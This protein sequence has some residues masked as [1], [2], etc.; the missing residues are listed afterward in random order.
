MQKYQNAIQDVNGNA[1]AGA[2][3]A[4]YLYGTTTPAT[5][6][7]DNGVTPIVGN[8]V[9]TSSV[10]EFFFYAANGRYSLTVTAVH[11]TS[12][13]YND[14]TLFDS[15]DY[16]APIGAGLPLQTGNSGKV[17]YTNGTN[18][19]WGAA[20][21]AAGLAV[22][23]P[24]T[25]YAVG[26]NV[27]APEGRP[28][29]CNTAH[30][31]AAIYNCLNWTYPSDDNSTEVDFTLLPNGN[32]GTTVPTKGKV[33]Y[34][35]LPEVSWGNYGV[36]SGRFTESSPGSGPTVTYYQAQLPNSV[37]K[38]QHLWCEF[39][40]AAS[41]S[42]GSGV[43]MLVGNYLFA[44][45][46]SQAPIHWG[47]IANVAGTPSVSWQS[48]PY[49]IP[50]SANG[51]Q[52]DGATGGLGMSPY[53]KTFRLD[54]TMD[55][56][57]GHTCG[58]INGQLALE[59]T[60]SNLIGYMTSYGGFEIQ[61]A[62]YKIKRFGLSAVLPDFATD[63]SRRN[64]WKG[65]NDALPGLAAISIT[66][67]WK[68]VST[69]VVSYDAMGV[70]VVDWTPFITNTSAGVVVRAVLATNSET[71]ASLNGAYYHNK[72][73]IGSFN[74]RVPFQAMRRGTP[75]T[76]EQVTLYIATESG[77]ATLQDQTYGDKIGGPSWRPGTGVN[78]T[79]LWVTTVAPAVILNPVP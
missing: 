11:F 52:F 60:D 28:I 35:G 48:G 8:S 10:G 69:F 16:T 39:E 34:F 9:T 37:D 57:T 62:S 3:V 68:S 7:S 33:V 67:T 29:V 78:L 19:N 36:V 63:G 44:A 14:I 46:P 73:C 26:A 55:I 71:Q 24:F 65:M 50:G 61:G 6:Y 17:L 72:L 42:A 74:G 20:G 47:F 45:P 66:S 75:Y 59:Y 54:I 13:A 77:T 4:V 64:V 21:L 30:T 18:P 49:N 79:K 70:V 1:V 22:W 32:A 56:T 53:G 31:S 12:D 38:V 40:V 27:L 51:P 43:T 25:A 41:P 15:A 5:I 58:F 76:S 2:T 23:S